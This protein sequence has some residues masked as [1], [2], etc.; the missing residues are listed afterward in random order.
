MSHCDQFRLLVDAVEDYALY[1]LD[2]A[3]K[4]ASWNTGAERIKGYSADEIIGNHFAKFF[5]TED[6]ESGKPDFVLSTA[7][8]LGK[9]KEEGFRVR[10]NGS[11]FWASVV[12]T[13]IVVDGVLKGFG[14]VTRDL[15]EPLKAEQALLESHS[16]LEEKVRTRTASL[17]TACAELLRNKRRDQAIVNS[18]SAVIW[19]WELTSDTF[20]TIPAWHEYTGLEEAQVAGWNW[21]EAIHPEDRTRVEELFRK[22]IDSEDHFSTECRIHRNTNEHRHFAVRGVPLRDDAG[23]A[24][25]WV[26]ICTDITDQKNLEAQLQHAQKIEAIGQ[27]AGGIAHDFN[28]ILTVIL[29]HGELL[30]Y[31]TLLNDD[32]RMMLG[33][34]VKA[35]ER[36]AS[37]TKQ[38]LTFSRRSLIELKPVN[39]NQVVIE[40][41]GML[42]RMIGEDI[43][44][45]TNLDPL[46]GLVYADVGQ[47]GQVLMNLALN[48]RDAMPSG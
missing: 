16:Q 32:E 29:S 10:K 11:K 25:E 21:I 15:T 24:L 22:A 36:A 4:I 20:I 12:V 19:R 43:D 5:T 41:E 26:G 17:E 7:K 42:R 47:L 1:M 38:L 18:I 39:V 6:R 37:L 33:E 3:G 31:S 35:G 9:Y 23:Q 34:I 48:S 40:I 30:L 8:A 44:L 27:F 13:P 28:N 14:K 46:T 45:R 2:P